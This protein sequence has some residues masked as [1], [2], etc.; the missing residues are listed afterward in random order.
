MAMVRLMYGMEPLTAEGDIEA[1]L[2]IY[3]DYDATDNRAAAVAEELLVQYRAFG[4]PLA[5]RRLSSARNPDDV[6]RLLHKM[7]DR[8]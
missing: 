2:D 5:S 4:R 8:D 6:R 3:L 7:D 1:V